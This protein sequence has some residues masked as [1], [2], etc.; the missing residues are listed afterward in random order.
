MEE[1][2]IIAMIKNGNQEGLRL[3]MGEMKR[4]VYALC[5]KITGHLANK[6]DLE[7]LVADTFITVWKQ[8]HDYH[9]NKG[10]LKTWVYM[11]AKY[12]ALTFKRKA[13]KNKETT[14]INDTIQRDGFEMVSDLTLDVREYAEKLS[15]EDKQLLIRR[16]FFDEKIEK[17]ALDLNSTRATLDTRMWRIRKGLKEFFIGEGGDR[18]ERNREIN[19]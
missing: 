14:E 12:N 13:E 5:F 18:R 3:L 6:E 10:A 19:G 2:R 16:C 15:V 1:E 9:P 7:E 17:I 11:I 8:I 4:N